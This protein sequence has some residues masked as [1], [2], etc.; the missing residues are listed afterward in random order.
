MNLKS[1][2][3][4]CILSIAVQSVFAISFNEFRDLS[5]KAVTPDFRL[6]TKQSVETNDSFRIVYQSAL[7]PMISI[8]ISWFPDKDSFREEDILANSQEFDWNSM[9]CLF[10]SEPEVMSCL[11]VLLTNNRGLFCYKITDF[12]GNVSKDELINGIE[13]L[14]FSKF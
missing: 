6:D 9:K 2:I 1:I 13:E 14:D 8:T 7:D 12:Q 11:S 3:L 4:L 5:A 10:S